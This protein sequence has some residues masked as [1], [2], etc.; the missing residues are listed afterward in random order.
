MAFP[1]KREPI[2]RRGEIAGHG[3]TSYQPAIP[4]CPEAPQN[5]TNINHTTNGAVT[6]TTAP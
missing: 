6:V 5:T 1:R 3:H 2:L 4:A